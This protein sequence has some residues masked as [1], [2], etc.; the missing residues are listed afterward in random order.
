MNEG[1][2]NGGRASYTSSANLD[3]K[4]RFFPK[5][6]QFSA[7]FI[8]LNV[9]IW[10]IFKNT[11]FTDCKWCK[12]CKYYVNSMVI[13]CSTCKKEEQECTWVKYVIYAVL[14]LFRFWRNLRNLFRKILIPRF[15]EFTKKT[16]LQL[17]IKS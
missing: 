8:S 14:P 2:S 17:W 13:S 5:F 3:L 1:M 7:K 9:Q 12:I 15:S 10:N 16:L 4:K 6:V 11:I